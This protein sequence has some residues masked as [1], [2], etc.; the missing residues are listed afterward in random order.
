MKAIIYTEYGSPDILQFV[1]TLKPTPTENEVLVKIVA[2]S[3]NPLDW[4]LMRGEPFLARIEAGFRKPKNNKLGADFSGV[5]EQVGASTTQFKKGDKVFG[6]I[7]KNGLGAFAEYVTTTENTLALNPVN[8]SF[9]QAAALPTA[10]LTALQGLRGGGIKSGQKVL[11]NGASG[12]VGS[13]AVQIAKSFGAEVTA[14]CSGNNSELVKSIGAD[15]VIDYKKEDFTNNGKKYDLI[16]C[17]VGNRSVA[18]YKNALTPQG[19]CVVAGFT[20]LSRLFE[21]M[22]VGKLTSRSSG[23]KV[24]LMK[25]MET[26]QNDLNFIKKL[27]E[28][29]KVTSVIDRQYPLSQT[30]EAIRYLETGRA[31]GK[32]I[33]NI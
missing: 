20:S 4:H 7:F 2:A 30:A 14:V 33:I 24:G 31:K 25:T 1:E 32:V 12:G 5:V 28:S 15:Y 21:H 10:A 18:D 6:N 16:F 3:A 17:A 29:G 13:F 26:D 8:T 27:I 22:L 11:I 23:Q 9:E 19:V